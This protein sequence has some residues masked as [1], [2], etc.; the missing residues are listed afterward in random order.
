MILDFSS[1][2][3]CCVEHFGVFRKVVTTR[4]SITLKRR[5]LVEIRFNHLVKHNDAPGH[6]LFK[7]W[8]WR[9]FI[10]YISKVMEANGHRHCGVVHV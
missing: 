7:Q 6:Q 10:R 1:F 5:Y 2:S 9:I 4:I 8:C 3:I